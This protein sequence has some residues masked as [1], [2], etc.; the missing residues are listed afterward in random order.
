MTLKCHYRVPREFDPLEKKQ[1]Y[2]YVSWSPTGHGVVGINNAMAI[3]MDKLTRY[4][5]M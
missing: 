4:K 2:Q 1:D 3:Q 5:F